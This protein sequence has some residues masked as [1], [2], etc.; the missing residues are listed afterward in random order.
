[1]KHYLMILGNLTDKVNKNMNYF[2]SKVALDISILN[3]KLNVCNGVL[4]TEL[5]DL[6]C[7]KGSPDTE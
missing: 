7:F 3:A 2:C 1:M 4:D 6:L 5:N